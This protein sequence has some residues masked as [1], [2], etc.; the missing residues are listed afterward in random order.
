MGSFNTTVARLSAA[1]VQRLLLWLLLITLP[2]S[3]QAQFHY[4]TENG[5]ITITR[6]D[7]SNGPAVIPSSIDGLPVT[8]I[9]DLAFYFCTGLTSVTIPD[10]VTTIGDYAFYFCT[11][12]TNVAI[13]NS[14]TNL[15]EAAFSYCT[16]LTHVTIPNSVTSIGDDA[17]YFC[18]SLNG[19][20]VEALNPVYGSLD[21]VLFDK[22]RTTLLQYPA[23]KAGSYTL[24]N[25][26]THV[27]DRA[28][29]LCTGLTRVTVPNSVTNVGHLAFNGCTSLITIEVEA[30]NPVYVSLDGVLFDKGQFTLLQY[31]EG[32][33]GSYAVPNSVTNLA[34]GAFSYCT[35]LTSV[36][37]P[38]SLTTIGDYAFDGC[39][40]LTRMTI[41]NSVTTIGRNAFYGC[42]GL[43]SVPI[44]NRVATIG[45][46]SFYNCKS[47]TRVT[48]PN[49]VTNIGYFAFYGCAG[50][51]NVTIPNSVTTIGD[52]AFDGCT[53]LTSVNFEGNAPLAGLNMFSGDENLTVYRL[54]GTTGWSETF[55]DRPTAVW[56]LPYPV[57]LSS[58]PGFGAA[59]NGFGFMISWATNAAVVVE[60]SPNLPQPVW[61]PMSTNVL[62]AGTSQFTDPLWIAHPARLYRIVPQ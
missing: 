61:T 47:L 48:V 8:T 28:F 2:A 60:T 1:R 62:T 29:S 59:V 6:Y 53:G 20:E 14:V 11:S 34:E 32:K 57:I 50:L 30:L 26:V 40:G 38:N 33:A 25:S 36:T 58:G 23:V 52:Y 54:P 45:I 56:L 44:P 43:T 24:P 15:A 21:G 3:V 46:Y 35:G 31:P 13:P 22:D 4:T 5:E 51:T 9:G 55:A 39:T 37:I 27:R 49:S 7:C 10:S 41:P 18:T 42:T 17:F 12:M 16:G 19:I